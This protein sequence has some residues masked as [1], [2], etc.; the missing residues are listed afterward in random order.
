MERLAGR[1]TR[2]YAELKTFFDKLEAS[3]SHLAVYEHYDVP[4]PKDENKFIYKVK[5]IH[6]HFQLEDLTCK[7]D[8]LKNWVKKALNVT[9]FAAS[10]WEFATKISKG[11]KKGQ[12]VNRDSLIQFHKGV[13]PIKQQK[14]FTL[15]FINEQHSK[16]YIPENNIAVDSIKKYVTIQ[17]SPKERKKRQ[18]DMLQDMKKEYGDLTDYFNIE[19]AVRAVIKVHKE[20]NLLISEYKVKDY[21]LSMMDEGTLVRRLTNFCSPR[22]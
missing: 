14:G 7:T 21:V 15:D 6:C 3:C 17:E 8:T 20:N 10:D 4:H 13:Y 12:P 9:E 2:S 16:S 22:V 18:W 5:R 1:I 11:V 19:K